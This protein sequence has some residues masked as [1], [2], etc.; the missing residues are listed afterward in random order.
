[1]T[2]TMDTIDERAAHRTNKERL[3]FT[4]KNLFGLLFLDLLL[5]LPAGTLNWPAAWVYLGLFQ[6]VL[7]ASSIYT[8]PELLRDER[9][10][11][12]AGR[13]SWDL[14]QLGMG[15]WHMGNGRESLLLQSR[16]HST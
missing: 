16:P 5:F 8:D 7:F 6:L 12:Q 11:G 13:K 15:L 3:S 9:G 14:I 10:V 1:M 2:L 4:I